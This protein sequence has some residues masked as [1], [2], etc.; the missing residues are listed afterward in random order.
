MKFIFI[1]VLL[2]LLSGCGPN[3]EG[4]CNG[5]PSGWSVEESAPYD[6]PNQ[7]MTVTRTCVLDASEEGECVEE[8]CYT[9]DGESYTATSC[10]N[11]VTGKW[12]G[13]CP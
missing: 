2:V 13:G 5:C 4:D 1:V 3:C 11:R 8:T 6:V 7:G 9:L 12:E 10:V